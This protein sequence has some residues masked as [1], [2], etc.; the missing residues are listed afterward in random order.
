MPC[1]ACLRTKIK[2]KITKAWKFQKTPQGSQLQPYLWLPQHRIF[3]KTCS[4]PEEIDITYMSIKWV[5]RPLL[6]GL[7]GTSIFLK[8]R[9]RKCNKKTETR[10]AHQLMRAITRRLFFSSVA[11]NVTLDKQESLLRPCKVSTNS[12]SVQLH[13]YISLS[14][15]ENNITFRN[16][17]TF[18]QYI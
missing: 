9:S 17:S 2:L 18:P 14:K 3:Y 15:S 6:V 8:T 7:D 12:L 5:I 10:E 4:A 11:L 1:L 16:A 13:H